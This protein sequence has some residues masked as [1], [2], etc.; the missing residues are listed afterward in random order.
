[1]RRAGGSAAARTPR[2]HRRRA[3]AARR[4]RPE[5]TWRFVKRRALA[6]TSR[7]PSRRLAPW[8]CT[9]G[10]VQQR[11]HG[12]APRRA[13]QGRWRAAQ[14]NGKAPPRK[15]E[16]AAQRS[17]PAAA[18]PPRSARV[19]AAEAAAEA[20]PAAEA[21]AAPRVRKRTAAAAAL[22]DAAGAAAADAGGA[23]GEAEEAP[24]APTIAFSTGLPAAAPANWCGCVFR[25]RASNQGLCFRSCCAARTLR[26]RR[27]GP[28][29]TR[30]SR[31]RS[32]GR[33]AKPPT[34]RPSFRH[35]PSCV[36]PAA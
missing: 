25:N 24:P 6:R 19:T 34:R 7:A 14:G 29:Y 8:R 9:C 10:A 21:P 2:R 28:A 5:A 12:G 16:A 11:A 23:G 13:L 20:A 36:S 33:R 3:R 22:D 27:L 31:A 4:A 1:M 35:P 17:A 32:A 30:T 26:P 15:F 18:M